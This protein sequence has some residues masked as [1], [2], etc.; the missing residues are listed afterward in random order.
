MNRN[1][2]Y[3]DPRLLP[4]SVIESAASGDVDAINQVLKH[5]EG[6]IIALSTRRLYDEYGNPHYFVDN[7]IRR[8]LET[9]LIIKIQQF[10]TAA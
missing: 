6:Y 2:T 5:Y 1:S 3:G 7:E 8:T 4:F 10:D 9:K